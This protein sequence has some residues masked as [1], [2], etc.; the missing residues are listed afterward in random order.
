MA[1]DVRFTPRLNSTQESIYN[2]IGKVI[3][4]F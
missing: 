1:R 2:D 3:Q 4:V